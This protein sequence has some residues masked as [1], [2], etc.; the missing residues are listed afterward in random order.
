MI[1]LT[2]LACCFT[3]LGVPLVL[4][5]AAGRGRCRL[6]RAGDYDSSF[7]RSLPLLVGRL[8]LADSGNEATSSIEKDE[9]TWELELRSAL[10]LYT[11]MGMTTHA[12]RVGRTLGVAT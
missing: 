2:A 12:E 1:V 8:G 5:R 3:R 6:H 7:A 11:E 9:V 10:E 4:G